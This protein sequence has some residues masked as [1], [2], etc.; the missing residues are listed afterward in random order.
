MS[1]HVIKDSL[2][3]VG[4][5]PQIGHARGHCP[6]NVVQ[7]P[8]PDVPIL[9]SK[10]RDALVESGLDICRELPGRLL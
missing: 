4:L 8:R 10:F 6:A 7:A 5:D 9:M 1:R 3:N 2:N